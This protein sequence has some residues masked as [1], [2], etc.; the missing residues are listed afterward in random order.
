MVSLVSPEFGTK[1]RLIHQSVDLA[2][3]DLLVKEDDPFAL[4]YYLWV[5]RQNR[6]DLTNGAKLSRWAL[7]WVRRIF[8]D[9]CIGR[10]KDEE[11][12]SAAIVATVLYR[13]GDL[14]I[15]T[16]RIRGMLLGELATDLD[17]G[18]IP[19]GQPIY[20]C[21]LLRALV[22]FG[23]PHDKIE[24]S[25]KNVMDAL[26]TH[27]RTGRAL[28][29]PFLAEIL[30]DIGDVDALTKLS[31]AVDGA[32]ND[33]STDWES[34]IY[35][36]QSTFLIED[37]IA[38]DLESFESLTNLALDSPI[39]SYAMVG[40]EEVTPLAD[41]HASISHLL[42]GALWDVCIH[43]S[44]HRDSRNQQWILQRYSNRRGLSV[45]AYSFVVL[46]SLLLWIPFLY[47][48]MP[49]TIG[50]FNYWIRGEYGAMSSFG[51]IGYLIGICLFALVVAEA[52]TL[53]ITLWQ[54]LVRF[55]LESDQRILEIARGPALTILKYW[56]RFVGG[57]LFV[58]FLLEALIPGL[59]HAIGR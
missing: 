49:S 24:G 39:W 7:T 18:K 2:V 20:G 36:S 41:S 45:M 17:R 52:L 14:Q 15:E 10:R 51:A 50:A 31:G 9:G 4:A 42:R 33:K 23:Y 30:N 21:V 53:T 40:V 19:F 3:R 8:V 13:S 43:I 55:A 56:G 11:L 28:G 38:L 32:L 29:I 1:A 37:T 26:M 22:E 44:R 46:I 16:D 58:G 57:T 48:L 6:I 47:V 54:P 25:L 5:M 35:L 27:L 59:L 12:A 34:L